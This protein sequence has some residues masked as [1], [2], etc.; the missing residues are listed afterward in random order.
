MGLSNSPSVTGKD[1][2]SA[3]Y[4]TKAIEIP[5]VLIEVGFVTNKEDAE[6]M[7]DGQWQSNIAMGICTGINDYAES[8]LLVN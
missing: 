1:Y 6:K 3:Y 5:S 2:A 7:T 8:S 4:V